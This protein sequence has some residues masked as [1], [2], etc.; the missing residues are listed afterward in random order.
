MDALINLQDCKEFLT[1]TLNEQEHK[2]KLAGTIDT[3]YFC[4]K[5]V[6]II[7]G[8]KNTND[9]TSR[10]VK[11]KN[12]KC[13]KEIL[14]GVELLDPR[15]LGRKNYDTYNEGSSIYI[16]EPGLYSLIMHSNAVFAEPFQTL[17]YETILPSIRKYGSYQIESQLSSAMEQLAIKDKSEQE[18]KL[19]AERAEKDAEEQRLRLRSETKRLREQVK[20]TLEFN[21]ATKQIEPM[22]YVYMCT[23]EYYQRQ[24]KFKFG[25]VQ[26][27]EL[28]KSRLTQY[29]S[30]ESNSEA[31]FFV[32]VRK[33]VSYRSI[34]QA[35]Y[36]VCRVNSLGND[37][38]E[39]KIQK[40]KNTLK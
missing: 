7:L 17:V 22:E 25:G 14:E 4:G 10:H 38:N 5:D 37:N 8:Y 30:G 39:E 9:A 20:R 13:L 29:N 35:V 12:K 23:T 11:T 28:L 19:R 18:L 16:N 40:I 31:H 2:I 3:P 33:T 24:H 26:T 21:Q 36:F 6:C 15:S 34:E 1:I 27:F 32:Y